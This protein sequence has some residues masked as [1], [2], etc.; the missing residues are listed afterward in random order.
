MVY[1]ELQTGRNY[2]IFKIVNSQLASYTMHTACIIFTNSPMF[3]YRYM[4]A[5][6]FI[7]QLASYNYI[8][9]I[10]TMQEFTILLVRIQIY[11]S[12]SPCSILL[13][14]SHT[15]VIVYE[16]CI[17]IITQ[18]YIYLYM[19]CF[20]A[21]SHT[22]YSVASYIPIYRIAGYLYRVP[23]FAFFREATQ[24]REN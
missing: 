5:D 10:A 24:S 4:V 19:S 12:N 8:H 3:S 15:I 22:Y 11:Y 20:H 14:Y 7:I 23:I 17:T 9:S 16:Y 18:A 1:S 21:H 6:T 13:S 2:C